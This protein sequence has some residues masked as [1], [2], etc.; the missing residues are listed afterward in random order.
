MRKK[1]LAMLLS[2]LLR[3]VQRRPSPTWAKTWTLWQ[4]TCKWYRRPPTPA[5]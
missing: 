3:S 1:L 2:L 4:K 5:S